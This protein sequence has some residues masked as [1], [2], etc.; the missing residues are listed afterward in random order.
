MPNCARIS[1]SRLLQ[2]EYHR[3]GDCNANTIKPNNKFVS[4]TFFK[5]ISFI[6]EPIATT[7]RAP[8]KKNIV[9]IGPHSFPIDIPYFNHI[10]TIFSQ[11]FFFNLVLDFPYFGDLGHIY[12]RLRLKFVIFCQYLFHIGSLFLKTVKVRSMVPK[13]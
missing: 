3:A 4:P 12:Y 1:L 11:P 7:H 6:I 8:V 10:R 2:P 13:R 9:F 5:Q